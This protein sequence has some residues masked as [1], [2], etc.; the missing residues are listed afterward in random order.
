MTDPNRQTPDSPTTLRGVVDRLHDAANKEE[1]SL[2]DVV[3]G[4]GHASFVPVLLVPALAVVTP[5]SGVPLFSSTCGIL[6]ALIAG[7]MLLGRRHLWLPRWIMKRRV[8]SDRLRKAADSLR[9]PADWLDAH[10]GKRL[11]VLVRPP[12]DR[13]LHLACV[14]CGIAMPVLELVPFTSSILGAAVVLLAMTLLVRD[15][16]LALLALAVIGAAIWVGVQ[17]V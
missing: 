10:T 6:I 13:L 11:S 4:L 14:L 3:E 9:K 2:N 12:M 8:P 5:L 7:Q 1:T 17:V 15:G 16:L